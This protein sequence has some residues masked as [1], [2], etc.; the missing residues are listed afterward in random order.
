[1][2]RQK[3]NKTEN[4]HTQTNKNYKKNVK[5]IWE[6]IKTSKEKH[7]IKQKKT[8]K[9]PNICKMS[10]NK[11]TNKKRCLKHRQ[12]EWKFVKACTAAYRETIGKL[13]L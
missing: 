12:K 1:M 4:K 13:A 3:D 9:T 10:K 2:C 6:Y 7:E 5:L 11:Q 8:Y